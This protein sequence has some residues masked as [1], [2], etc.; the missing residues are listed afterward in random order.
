MGY[1]YEIICA[2]ATL[3]TYLDLTRELSWRSKILSKKRACRKYIDLCWLC[4]ADSCFKLN[5]IGCFIDWLIDLLIDW[6]IDWFIVII[7]MLWQTYFWCAT[8]KAVRINLKKISMLNANVLKR[9][10]YFR[11]WFLVCNFQSNFKINKKIKR[12]V[13]KKYVGLF[14]N[15]IYLG[16]I[17]LWLKH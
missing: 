15:F 4:H 14:S 13:Q 6:L 9:F 3:V 2:I 11:G 17:K 1:F 7:L 12:S 16:I 5:E 8:N 10:I